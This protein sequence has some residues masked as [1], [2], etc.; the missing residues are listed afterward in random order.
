MSESPKEGGWRVCAPGGL[1]KLGKGT[2]ECLLLSLGL[3]S[4][5]RGGPCRVSK[6]CPTHPVPGGQSIS[7]QKMKDPVNML[8]EGPGH[9]CHPSLYSH[10]RPLLISPMGQGWGDPVVQS[11]SGSQSRV[12]CGSEGEVGRTQQPL[13]GQ[14]RTPSLPGSPLGQAALGDVDDPRGILEDTHPVLREEK[15][16][17]GSARRQES[18][19][20]AQG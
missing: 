14:V 3:S 8:R 2:G 9:Q 4:S 1:G 7:T 6:A 17:P 12:L 19:P 20:G 5:A 18:L 13:C 16:L 15:V 10:T 11:A